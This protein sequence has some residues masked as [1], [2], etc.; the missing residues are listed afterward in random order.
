MMKQISARQ[1]DVIQQMFRQPFIF[2]GGLHN[3]AIIERVDRK[4]DDFMDT[5]L[6]SVPLDFIIEFVNEKKC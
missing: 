1:N 2:R 6:Y 3:H 5:Y 4:A